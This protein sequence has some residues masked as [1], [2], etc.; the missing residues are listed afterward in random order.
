VRSKFEN[1]GFFFKLKNC[2]V[3]N[4]MYNLTY[5]SSA[6]LTDWKVDHS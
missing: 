1:F 5:L 2:K 6:H 3:Y 4:T